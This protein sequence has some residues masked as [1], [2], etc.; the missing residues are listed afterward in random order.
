MNTPA[1]GR[2]VS[3][4][5][6]TDRWWE[7]NGPFQILQD[8]LPLRLEWIMRIL[9]QHSFYRS[10]EGLD[11]DLGNLLLPLQNFTVLDGGCGGGFLSESLARLGAKVTGIDKSQEAI[12]CAKKHQES[13]QDLHPSLENIHYVHGDI[14][15]WTPDGPL[16][17]ILLMEV[18]EHV[19][20]PFLLL[21]RCASW[22]SSGGMLLGSTLNRTALSYLLGIQVAERVLGWVPKGT[23][24]WDWF[25]TPKEMETMLDQAGLGKVKCQGYSLSSSLFSAATQGKWHFSPCQAINYFFAGI[26][27]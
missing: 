25:I 26:K 20:H 3:S 13:H 16:D 15:S 23:H 19:S 18:L 9:P 24:R 22:L 11:H 27:E 7:K 2:P 4:P 1:Y 6:Q 21:N 5:F 10:R 17:A 14:I 8:L 12:A